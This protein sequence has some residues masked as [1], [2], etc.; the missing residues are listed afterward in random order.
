MISA[1]HWLGS[2]NTN[3]LSSYLKLVGAYHWLSSIDTNSFSWY[4]TLVSASQ[5]SSNS[6]Q[7]LL[8]R[9]TNRNQRGLKLWLIPSEFVRCSA[10]AG[11]KN[12]LHAQLIELLRLNCS[13][14]QFTK[15]WMTWSFTKTNKAVSSLNHKQLEVVNSSSLTTKRKKEGNCS[16][17]ILFPPQSDL[18]PLI[19]FFIK[20]AKIIPQI[21]NLHVISST[22]LKIIKIK[23]VLLYEKACSIYDTKVQY[24]LNNNTLDFPR[25]S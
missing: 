11:K 8:S 17:D 20:I 14:I 13:Q 21:G 19:P 23:N 10:F 5:S 22:N 9:S 24:V 6:V 15:N 18:I 3:R 16:H 4:L 7:R 1:N 12:W 25:I 2:I